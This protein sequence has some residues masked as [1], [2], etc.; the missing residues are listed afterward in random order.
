MIMRSYAPFL[1]L[2]SVCFLAAPA[3]AMQTAAPKPAPPKAEAKPPA[4]ERKEIKLTEKALK[5]YVGEYQMD[6]ERTLTVTLEN[7]YLYGQP[8][9]QGKRQIFAE[10]Q[11]KFFLKDLP[12]E[13]TFQKDAKG[14]VTTMIMDQEGR[15]Q[16]TLKKIK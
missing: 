3:A 10:S 6:A 15:P 8:T 7:G 2:A 9:G 14:A 13:L 11:T 12:V 16:R 1:V 4:A 5:A